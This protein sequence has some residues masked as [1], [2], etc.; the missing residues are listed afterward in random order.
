MDNC[1]VFAKHVPGHGSND[2]EFVCWVRVCLHLETKLLK[3]GF[4]SPGWTIVNRVALRQ[5][6][7]PVEK[8]KQLGARLVNRRKDRH[9]SLRLLSE[10]LNDSDCS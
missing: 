8:H 10:Q 1:G 4:H 6:N 7:H 2:T 5:E 9:A 3:V